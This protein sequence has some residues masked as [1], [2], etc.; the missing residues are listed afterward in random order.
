MPLVAVLSI[1][2]G[3]L[4]FSQTTPFGQVP[5]GGTQTVRPETPTGA[6]VPG[7]PPREAQAQVQKGSARLRGRV[8]AAQAGTPLRRAQ[9]TVVGAQTALRRV[10]TTDSEGRYEFAEFPAG[11]FTVT[12]T[13]AGYVPLQYGQ[14]R[15]FEEGTPVTV[16]DGQTVERIDFTLPRG[17]VIVVRVMDDF[18]EPLAGAQVQV[19]RYQYGPDGQRRLTSVPSGGFGLTSTDDRGEFRAYGLMPGEYVVSASERNIGTL[20]GGNLN[21]AREGGLSPTFYPGTIS[22]TEAQAIAVGVGEEASAQF[23]MVSARLARI[24][25]TVV[26]SQ[27]RPAAGAGL[28]VVT[29]MGSSGFSSSAAGT[30]APDGTFTIA[31]IAPGEHSIDVRPQSRPGDA[32]GEAASVPIVVSGDITG[33]QIVTGKGTTISG[34]VVFEGSSTRTPAAPRTPLRVTASPSDPSRARSLPFP[35]S[36]P[37]SNGAIE[38]SGNFQIA[39]ASGRVFFGVNTPPAWVLKSVTLDGENITDEP[40]DLTDTP[41]VSGVVIRMT[42]KLTQISGQVSDDR[43]RAVRDYVVVIQP[44]EQKEPIVASRWVRAVRA[45]TNG[46]FETRGMRPGRYLATAI[47]SLEQGRQFAP[48]FQEQLRRGGREFSVREGESVTLDLELTP[49][50]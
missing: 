7:M 30:V 37:L 12:A 21:D 33:L 40:L 32:D 50:L 9:I 5:A 42:D 29:P 27:G 38:E 13:K 4:A 20:P 34:R 18:G 17:S 2:G 45:G 1:L 46:R 15:P 44:T 31:G 25:G 49:G 48:E 28:S 16:A 47:D 36:N 26:D 41:S 39:G 35:L 14:K 23:S 8:V 11:R 19:Q 24:S 43:G 6:Q 10:T 3:S 22:G